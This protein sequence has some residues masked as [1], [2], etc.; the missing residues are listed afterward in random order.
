MKVFAVDFETYY[1]KFYS[2]STFGVD[3]YCAHENFDPY[4][5]SVVGDGVSFVGDPRTFD[6]STIA[7]ELWVSHNAR[8]DE[9]VYLEMESRG[10]VPR[11]N[12]PAVWHC[13]A[14]LSVYFGYPR[15]L[16]NVAR[17]LFDA[18]LD[19][20]TRAKMLGKH[21]NDLKDDERARLLQYALDDS[22]EC[23]RVWDTLSVDWPEHER[24]V[25]LLN[26]EM[27]RYGVRIDTDK[28]D[29]YL[30]TLRQIL[31]ESAKVIP[32]EW[33][34]GKTPLSPLKLNRACRD[35]GIPCPGSLAA[36]SEECAQ[37]EDTYGDDYPWVGAMRNW[38]RAN[39]LLKK[40]ETIHAR[41]RAD[42]TMPFSIKYFGGH[43]GRFSGDGGFNI[44]NLPRGDLM[45][46]DMRSLIIARP[47][48]VF[49]ISDLAQ[50]EARVT[51]WL[52]QDTKTLEQVKRGISVYEAHA[53]ATMGWDS[54]NG[55]LK[56]ANPALYRLAKARVLGLGF[57]CGAARFQKLARDQYGIELDD[58]EANDTVKLFRST[59]PKIIRLWKTLQRDCT[60]CA[61]SDFT[62][63]LPSRRRLTYRNVKTSGDMTAEIVAGTRRTKLY[64]GKLTENLVQAVARD[65][66]V[67][68]MLRLIDNGYRV[69]FHVHDE[70]I[71]EIDEDAVDKV[72]HIEELV[73]TPAPWAQTCPV[74]V[75]TATSKV[76]LK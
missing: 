15:S 50:I 22:I 65:I 31:W 75:E 72:T 67:A 13:T 66:F 21:L 20:Q 53:I 43:T 37:W 19:K 1:D 74:G 49:V 45:G 17:V 60:R 76:Y 71:L 28:L 40:L 63:E 27:G 11:G 62:V 2:I 48:K 14:D 46:V 30:T 36:D 73:T 44:Q 39:I 29:K 38:R 69:L 64:G 41:V 24:N 56:T 35:A 54:A 3:G 58:Q 8:F 32:W 47:G 16:A 52:A 55:T 57:G 6:W 33:D 23:K 34:T 51:L 42:G 7:G 9:T 59:N 12:R 5:V 26:R 25:S 18:K 10:W 4:M 61:G 68:G 70:Y